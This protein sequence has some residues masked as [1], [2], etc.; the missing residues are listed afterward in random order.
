M[1][2]IAVYW[3][4]RIKTYGFQVSDD[5]VMIELALDP[6][7]MSEHGNGLTILG[8]NG[9]TFQFVMM[10]VTGDHP[11]LYLLVQERFEKSAL[12]LLKGYPAAHEC[13]GIVRASSVGMI[14]FHG[15]HYGE[16]YGIAAAVFSVLAGK[17]ITVLLSGCSASSVYLVMPRDQLPPAAACLAEAFEV[18][19]KPVHKK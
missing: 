12:A 15:P 7:A 9:I 1:E 4:S 14:Q 13:G 18:P 11:R 3:E 10:Q 19:T 16:R 8:E 17:G 2:T 5:L 6:E